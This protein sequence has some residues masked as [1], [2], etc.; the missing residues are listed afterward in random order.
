MEY[1]EHK[2]LSEF[3]PTPRYK[4]AYLN[5]NW[6]WGL[7]RPNNLCFRQRDWRIRL[8]FVADTNVP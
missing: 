5:S 4:V 8:I 6:V 1:N 2:L 3:D 7:I